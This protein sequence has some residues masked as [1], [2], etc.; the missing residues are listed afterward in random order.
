M[1]YKTREKLQTIMN[2]TS[3]ELRYM[4]RRNYL[5]NDISKFNYQKR[6]LSDE[7][8]K[9][10]DNFWKPYTKNICYKWHEFFYSITGNFDPAYIPED[11]M[12]TDI[13]GYLNDWEMAHGIDNKNNYEFY[14]PEIKHPKVAFRRIKN[15]YHLGDYS[16]CSI[17]EALENAMDFN[18]I[19]IK[20]SIET[21]NGSSILFWNK[22][23]GKDK[24]RKL[25]S[26]ESV[27]IIAQEFVKQH[28]SLAEFNPSSVNSIRIVT[29]IYDNKVDFL[30]AYL[31][32]GQEGTKIDN[33]CAGGMCSAV[34]KSGY[35]CGYAYDKRANKLYE[36]PTGKKF[37]SYRIPGWDKVLN[38][39]YSMHQKMG[40]FRIVSW[41][42][43]IGE[44]EEPIF[45]EMNLKYGAMEYHQLFKG[46]LFGDK[47]KA[48]LDDVYKKNE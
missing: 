23:D 41:D 27:D 15:I 20:R 36:S 13:E 25:I 33:V 2:S 46:P 11:L 1:N 31:R 28:H 12:L 42:I 43:A 30:C 34:D 38:K 37:D 4:I 29:L 16:V 7:Q 24:L 45:V 26:G 17:E 19:I 47:T 9:E 35:L 22:E 32:I 10:I 21:G 44:D 3:K 40:N 8:K 39:C 5:R 14:F 6:E 18:S 48:I